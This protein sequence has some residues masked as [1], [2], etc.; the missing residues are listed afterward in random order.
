MQ[1]AANAESDADGSTSFTDVLT[2]VLFTSVSDQTITSGSI[3]ITRPVT[4]TGT[5]T[6]RTRVPV[7]TSVGTTSSGSK[8]V[9]SP[10][11]LLAADFSPKVQ[12]RLQ[13]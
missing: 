1:V 13:Q 11:A 3:T 6:Q 7:P 9:Q 2:T 10:S 8:Y 5:T 4:S 12:P